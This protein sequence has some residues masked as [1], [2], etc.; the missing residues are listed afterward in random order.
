MRVIK[1]TLKRKVR[2]VATQA[3]PAAAVL[4]ELA[5]PTKPQQTALRAATKEAVL[6]RTH[7]VWRPMALVYITLVDP[8]KVEWNAVQTWSLLKHVWMQMHSSP[9]FQ[10]PMQVIYD[11]IVLG[12][13]KIR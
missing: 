2:W 9:D 1:T 6:G 4:P 13:S 10:G 12:Y 5:E 7:L 8:L 11:K 3:I